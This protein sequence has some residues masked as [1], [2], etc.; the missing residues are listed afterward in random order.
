[1]WRRMVSSVLGTVAGNPRRAIGP[2]SHIGRTCPGGAVAGI[3]FRDVTEGFPLLLD[4]RGRRVV[5]VGGGRVAVRRVPALWEAG[6]DVVI[7]S[8]AL[9]PYLAAFEPAVRLRPFRPDDLDGAWLVFACTDDADVNI[10][11]ALAA[12]V[13]GVFCVRA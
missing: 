1:M 11:V 10:E 12:E 5:V 3:T 8:P 6:A 4:L 9:D 13:R 7:V 2:C